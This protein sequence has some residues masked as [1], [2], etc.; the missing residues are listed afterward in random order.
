MPLFGDVGFINLSNIVPSEGFGGF[1][2]PPGHP[3]AKKQEEQNAT[4]PTQAEQ[5]QEDGGKEPD[6]REMIRTSFSKNNRDEYET[7]SVIW[8]MMAESKESLTRKEGYNVLPG[9]TGK[10]DEERRIFYMENR[11]DFVRLN[12][13]KLKGTARFRRKTAQDKHNPNDPNGVSFIGSS[14]RDLDAKSGV[15]GRFYGRG[16]IQITHGYNY[17]A[18]GEYL[19]IPLYENPD[20]ASDPKYS[21]AIAAAY[22]EMEAKRLK[23]KS[24]DPKT[25]HEII[26]PH[27]SFD[28]R[29]KRMEAMGYK[30][31]V[32]S[33][34]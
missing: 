20:M 30:L 21:A 17:K 5:K 15:A 34:K 1:G 18:V 8:H 26:R 4:A 6:F 14:V 31:P 32:R 3:N 12:D 24:L 2:W 11:G 28:E 7:E 16:P 9:D 13:K 10:T 29:V 23:K 33:S 27:E 19:G 22:I 25:L